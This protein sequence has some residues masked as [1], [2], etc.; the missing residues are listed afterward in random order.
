MTDEYDLNRAWLR[1]DWMQT[2]IGGRFYPGNPRVDDI[3]ERDIA[4]ALSLI[5]RYAGHIARFYSVAEHCVLMSR[6]VSP[7]NAL[8]ALLHDATEAYMSDVPKPVKN[9]L[10]GYVALEERVWTVIAM[11]FGVDLEIPREVHDADKRILVNEVE[12]LLPLAENWPT[13]PDSRRCR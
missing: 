2:S 1:G 6:A 9:V 12:A 10:P 4:H 7:E 13:W 11:K 5:C 8:T 3:N